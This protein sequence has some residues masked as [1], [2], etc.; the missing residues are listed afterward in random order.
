VH[1]TSFVDVLLLLVRDG[2]VLLAERY[3]TGYADGQWK[4]P[5][6]KL[7]EGEDLEA[8]LIRETREEIGLYLRR[9]AVRMV[10]SVH[11]LNPEGPARVGFFFH[12][13]AWNGEP[14]K[15]ARIGW[16]PM[17]K[18]PDNT[19][20]LQPRRCG[21]VPPRRAFRPPGLA[22]HRRG[23]PVE[24]DSTSTTAAPG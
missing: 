5:S 17:N 22:T 6:G 3:N 4:L 7:D 10:T 12:V 16:F 18:L 20:P 24:A 2:H 9:D 13:P 1:Y 11:Y 8:A 23:P 21:A 15:C 14:Y 19:V